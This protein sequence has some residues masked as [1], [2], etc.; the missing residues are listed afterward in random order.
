[1]LH[2]SQKSVTRKPNEKMTGFNAIYTRTMEANFLGC[3]KGGLI[4]R[5]IMEF[6]S[7][8]NAALINGRMK[9]SQ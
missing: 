7:I 2:L 5:L 8:L 1:M 4:L 9:E 6:L 3:G